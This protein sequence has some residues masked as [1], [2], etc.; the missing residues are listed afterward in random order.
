MPE[1]GNEK[2]N[3][4]NFRSVKTYDFMKKLVIYELFRLFLDE[5]SI[6]GLWN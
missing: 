3:C 5:M 1:A 6:M 2:K 4:T